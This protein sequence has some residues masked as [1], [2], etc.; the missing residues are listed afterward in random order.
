MVLCGCVS[1]M[2]MAIGGFTSTMR[3]NWGDLKCLGKLRDG[4]LKLKAQ[5]CIEGGDWDR[6]YTFVAW[7]SDWLTSALRCYTH[8]ML[9]T[10][11]NLHHDQH[12]LHSA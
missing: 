5:K 2:S 1:L 4:K 12:L 10:N 7:F 6:Q 8:L 3:M 9:P 11:S